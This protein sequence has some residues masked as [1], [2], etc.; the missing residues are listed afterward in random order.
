MFAAKLTHLSAGRGEMKR[1]AHPNISGLMGCNGTKRK[2]VGLSTNR[3][4]HFL[5]YRFH[6][7]NG[8][9]G[10]SPLIASH[11]PR[12][13]LEQLPSHTRLKTHAKQIVVD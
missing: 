3:E 4:N 13:A 5:R 2:V 1:A 10:I 12:S 11:R 6:E 9:D 7:D 8:E